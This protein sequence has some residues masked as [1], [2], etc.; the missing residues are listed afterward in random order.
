ME[1][2]ITPEEL[3]VL[4]YLRRGPLNP[5]GGSSTR[6]SRKSPVSESADR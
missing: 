5:H 1:V 3:L 4:S 6:P 2:R